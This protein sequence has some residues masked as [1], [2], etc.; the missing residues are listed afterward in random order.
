[1]T[2]SSIEDVRVRVLALIDAEYKSDSAFERALS[3]PA[4]TVSNWRRGRSAGFMNMLPRLAE[5][6]GVPVSEVMGLPL[7]EDNPHLSDEEKHLLHVYRK[8]RTL[9]KPARIAL[10]KALTEVIELYTQ[11]TLPM[12]EEVKSKKEH[13]CK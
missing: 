13:K 2:E 12:W 5:A 10:E 9:P 6:F 11:T 1:M 4:K 3:L 8:A 7:S